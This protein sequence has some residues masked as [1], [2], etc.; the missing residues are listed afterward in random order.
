MK[1][2]ILAA[3]LVAAPAAAQQHA[4]ADAAAAAT[5]IDPERLALAT[6]TAAYLLPEGSY[7]RMMDSSMSDWMDQMYQSMFNLNTGD[8]FQGFANREVPPALAQ[9][10]FRELMELCDPHFTERFEI[11]NRVVWDATKPIM[12]GIEPDVRA[13]LARAYA[14]K[15][16]AAQ[17]ADINRFLETESGRVYAAESFML[18]MDPEV[19][20]VMTSLMPRIMEVMPASAE[21]IKAATAHLPPPPDKDEM[22][23]RIAKLD[24]D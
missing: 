5:K 18:W 17:L 4:A 22:K 11:A 2:L 21:E 12:V 8:F 7:A 14:A 15:M 10:S 6:V 24:L 16:T 20:A 9:L 19:L 1:T 13:A 3:A 23:Q